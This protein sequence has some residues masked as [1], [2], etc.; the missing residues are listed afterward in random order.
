[1]QY[2]SYCT[3]ELNFQQMYVDTPLVTCTYMCQELTKLA[4]QPSPGKCY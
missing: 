1:M 2:I 4:D 3:A